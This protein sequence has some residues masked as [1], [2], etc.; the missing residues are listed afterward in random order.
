MSKKFQ[1]CGLGSGIVDVLL[2][3]SEREFS[4]LSGF[5]RGTMRLAEASEQQQL[6]ETFKTHTPALVSGGSIANSIIAVAQLGGRAALITTLGDDHFGKFYREECR[7]LG[8]EIGNATIASQPTGSCVVLVTPDAERTMRTC[9]GAAKAMGIPHLNR[10]LIEQSEWLFIEGYLL[11]N[12]ADTIAAIH[13]A[14]SWARAAGTKV[15]FSLSE[16]FVVQVFGAEVQRLL[17]SVDLLFAN[18]SEAAALTGGASPAESA[19]RM[20]NFVKNAVVTAGAA[21]IQIWDGSSVVHV[22]AFPSNPRDL[23]GAGD[24]LAGAYLFGISSGMSSPK[25]ARAACFMAKQVIERLGAR[26][27]SG[28]KEFWSEALVAP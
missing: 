23:T 21:G 22:P 12:G 8:I 4:T 18:E 7:S 2:E 28:V 5:E 25:A 6:L 1:V 27:P 20:K 19:A 10:E 26:L 9:L 24:M 3:I 13:Q 14:V 11:A 17:P 15:A 16:A